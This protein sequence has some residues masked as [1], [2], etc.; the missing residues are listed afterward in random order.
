VLDADR[1]G[2]VEIFFE[3]D[4]LQY[5]YANDVVVHACPPPE[6]GPGGSG[7]A[8]FIG[9]EGWVAVDRDSIAA[10]QPELLTAPLGAGA[11]AVYHSTSHAGN[12]LECVRSRKQPICDIATAHR[13][14]SAVILGGLALELKRTLK[15]DPQQEQ[16]INDDEANRLLS[17]TFRPPWLV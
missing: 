13:S 6:D 3:Q 16:F 14:A 15:W 7:G 9:S 12:F 10:S 4:V 8:R 5:R 2:P 17:A 1:S 11:A